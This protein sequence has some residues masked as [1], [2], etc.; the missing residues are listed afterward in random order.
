[1]LL[2]SLARIVFMCGK[3]IAEAIGFILQVRIQQLF[4]M[5]ASRKN[6]MAK[7]N[8][9]DMMNIMLQKIVEKGLGQV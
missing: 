4:K 2:L 8:Q 5:A 3:G 1:M 9:I 7:A 6:T